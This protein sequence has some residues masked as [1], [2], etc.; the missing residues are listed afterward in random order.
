MFKFDKQQ[1]FCTSFFKTLILLALFVFQMDAMFADQKPKGDD[2]LVPKTAPQMGQFDKNSIPDEAEIRAKA[3]SVFKF[4]DQVKI[5]EI[6]REKDDLG[7]THIR[8]YFY[9]NGSRIDGGMMVAHILNGKIESI[10]GDFFPVSVSS[11]PSIDENT[12]LKDAMQKINATTYRWQSKSEEARLKQ[13]KKDINATW[14]PKAELVYCPNNGD[15]TKMTLAYK[16]DIFANEPLVGESIYVDAVSGKVIYERSLIR[17]ADSRGSAKTK[18][19]GTQV[20]TA[21]SIS[22]T[23][24]DLEESGR[25]GGIYTFNMKTGTSYGSAVDFTD[26]DNYWNNANAAQDEVAG[27]AHWGAEMTYDFYF[28]NFGRN[29]FDNAG[30]IIYSYVHYDSKY[31][32]AFWDGTE[33]NYGD[34]DGTNFT[35][36]TALDVCGHEISHGFTQHASNLAYQ[37]ESGAMDEGISDIFGTCIEFYAKDTLADWI[38]GKD[39]TVN[40][41]GIRDMSAPKN[42]SQPNTYNGTYYVSTSGTPTATNDWNGVHTNS[43]VLNYWFYLIAHGGSGTND[44]S[45]SYS[46][47]GLGIV[48]AQ[49]IMFRTAFYY[50]TTSSTFS[51]ARNYSI[52]AAIDL[53]GGCSNEVKQVTNAWYAV[54]IGAAYSNTTLSGT[55]TIGGTSPDFTTFTK[56]VA[57]INSRGICGPVTFNVRNGSYKE[58]IRIGSIIGTSAVNTVTFQSQNLDSTKVILTYASSSSSANDYTLELDSSNYI[59]FR[60][61]TIQRT[62]TNTYCNVVYLMDNASYN[63]ISNNVLRGQY[64][65]STSLTVSNAVVNCDGSATSNN[66]IYNNGI[67]GGL[68]GLYFYGVTYYGSD[69]EIYN[70]SVD[71]FGLSGI[72]LGYELNPIIYANTVKSSSFSSTTYGCYG[73]RLE[74]CDKGMTVTKNMVYLSAKATYCRGAALYNCA[75]TSG[76]SDFMWNNFVRISSGLTTSTGIHL[77]GCAYMLTL[78]N[79]VLNNYSSSSSIAI[80]VDNSSLTTSTDYIYNNNIVNKGG[81][82]AFYI[83]GGSV[84]SANY[85]N[86]YTSGT[87]IGYYSGGYTSLSNWK[88]GTGYDANSKNV[89]PGYTSANDLH[90]S[91][92]GIN[93]AAVPIT[94][95]NDDIDGNFRD[96]ITPDIGA[97]EFGTLSCM[98]DTFTIGGTSPDYATFKAAVSD[99][100]KKGVCGNVVF[101]VRNGTYTEQ[102]RIGSIPGSS[103]SSTITFQSQLGDS[104]KVILQYASSSSSTNN[105]TLMLD[106]ASYVTFRQ[107]TIQRTGSSTYG[108]TIDLED[109][110]SNNFFSNDRLLS[111]KGGTSGV[112]Q[113]VIYSAGSVDN[114]NV[115]YNNIIRHGCY[116][117]AYG[118]TASAYGSNTWIFFNTIDSFYTEGVYLIYTSTPLVESNHITALPGGSSTSYGI[119]I[120]YTT[121]AG[122]VADNVIYLK[123]GGYGLSYTN[124]T[125]SFATPALI[126]NNFITVASANYSVGFYLYSTGYLD[127]VYN[128]VNNTSTKSNASAAYIYA[129]G[130]Y[131]NLLNNNFVNKGGGYAYY[132]L[133][134]VSNINSDYNNLY[135]SGTNLCYWNSSNYTSLGS[136]QK[137]TLIDI[138]D[139]NVDPGY[140]NTTTDLHISNRTLEYAGTPYSGVTE[141]IDMQTRNTTTPTIGADEIFPLSCLNGTYT[142]GGTSPDFASFSAAIS[143]MRVSGICGPVVFNV[144]DGSYLEKISIGKISGSSSINT[145]TFQSQSLDSSKVILSYPSNSTFND[146]VLTIDTAS[147]VTFNE[148]TI[149]RSGSSTYGSCVE[150]NYSN[151]NISITNCRLIAINNSANSYGIFSNTGVDSNLTFNN[152]LVRHGYYGI[153]LQGKSSTVYDYNTTITNNTL[154]SFTFYGIYPS[155]SNLVTVTGNTVT[156][157]NSLSYYGIYLYGCNATTVASNKIYLPSGGYG[158]TV[159]N[160]GGTS[161][162]PIMVYNNFV[163]VAGSNAS[164]GI[165]I[166]QQN[167][168]VDLYYN[169]VNMTNSN[170]GSYTVYYNAKLCTV[171]SYDN[172]FVNSGGGY[173]LLM[174]NYVSNVTSNYNDYYYAGT[175]GFHYNST[176]YS[177]FSSYKTAS[178]KDANSKNVN[179]GFTS[180]TDL[181]ISSSLLKAGTPVSGITDDIDGQTRSTSTPTIGADEI[182]LSFSNDAGISLI[183]TPDSNVCKGTSG[184]VVTLENYGSNSLSSATI[185][186]SMNDTVQTAYS[187]SGTLSSG[188]TT[189]VT[190][191]NYNFSGSKVKIKVWTSSPNAAV[192]SNTT[193]DTANTSTTV[194]PLPSATVGSATSICSGSSTTIGGSS[195]SGHTYSWTSN[196]SGFTSTSNNPSVSPTVSTTYRLIET[197]SY[198]CIK[199]DS[200]KISVN[201]LPSV[202]VG[203]AKSICKGS[204]TGI[205]GSSTTGYTYS[206]TSNPSGFTSTSSNPSVSPTVTTVYKLTTKITATGCTKSDSVKI[207][208]N[209]QPTP[210]LVGATSVCANATMKDSTKNNSGDTYAW[211]ISGGS[212]SSGSSTNSVV[213]KWGSSGSGSLKVVE[214]NGSGCKD[215]SSVSVTIN[216]KPTPSVSG[217]S[218]V[219]ASSSSS[220]ST[221]KNSGNTYSWTI[222]GGTVSSGAGT[223]AIGAKWGTSGSGSVQVVETNSSGCKDS[224]SMSITINSTPSATVG[225]ATSICNGDSITLGGSSVSGNTYSWTST[226]SGF[227]SSSAS[228]KVAPSSTITYNLTETTTA[229]GC[230]KNNSAKITVNARPSAKVA[231]DTSVCGNTVLSLGASTVVGD[232]YKWTS[233]PSGYSDTTSNPKITTRTSSTT[234]YLTETIASSGCSKTDSV[235]VTVKPSPKAF[236]GTSQG[237]CNGSS[238]ILGASSVLGNTYSWTS[239]PSGFTSTTANPNVSPTVNTTYYLTEKVTSSGCSKSDSVKI[240]VNPLPSATVASASTICSGKSTSIGAATVK[241]SKYSWTSNPSGFT[242]TTSNPSV[243][244]TVTTTYYLTETI[245][246]TGCQKSDSVIVTVKTTPAV[247]TASNNGPLCP[248]STLD[249]KASSLAGAT[250]SWT[251]PNTFSSSSQNPSVTNVTKA[252]SGLYSVTVTSGGCTSN[253]GTTNVVIYAAPKASIS[254]NGSICAFSTQSYSAGTTTNKYS[255]TVSGGTISSGSGTN[256]IGITWGSSGKTW[257]KL[258][259]TNSNSCSDSITD[260]ITVNALPAASTGSAGS[261]C[262]GSSTSIGNTSVAGNTYSWTSKPGGFTSTSSNPSVSPYTSTTYYLTETVTATGCSKSDSVK[263]TVNPLPTPFLGKL[264]TPLCGGTSVVYGTKGN[265]GSSYSWTIGN[266]TITSGAGTDSINVNWNNGPGF[267]PIKVVETNAAGCK[268]SAIDSIV[269]NM[270]P[271]AKYFVGKT[272]FG[273][274]TSFA[275]SSTYHNKQT[276]Y[277]GDGNTSTSKNPSHTYTST[278]KYTVSL[279]IKNAVGCYDSSGTI[280]NIAPVPNAHFTSKLTG[281]RI[282]D[283]RADDTT[284]SST[285]YL[286]DFGDSSSANGFNTVHAYSADSTYKIQLIINN[287]GCT[288]S[289]DSSMVIFTG[290]AETNQATDIFNLDIYPNPFNEITTLQYELGFS[291]KIKIAVYAMD[292]KLITTLAEQQQSAGIHQFILRPDNYNLNQG[293]YFL[294]ILVGDKVITKQLIRVK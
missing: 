197:S 248:A 78:Y 211:Y 207:T 230:S 167:G 95:I 101:M 64:A 240:T 212:I 88:T 119:N 30:G 188:S 165:Y 47:T 21:D 159:S 210:S 58:Q 184:V 51:D 118:G 28:K 274:A 65:Y 129:T 2:P 261:I 237:I 71:S 7:Y 72:H 282:Y 267:G 27:D 135:S 114:Y 32:N 220:Y 185:N 168:Y 288:S 173:S 48:E 223:N 4:N 3:A 60:K 193:N 277:F 225:S 109:G 142:I 266:G 176:A 290:I 138:H 251:G 111:I 259:E 56:A 25:G 31:N 234:Y 37:N 75:S 226:P 255:W 5:V 202:T 9:Y 189:N 196:P 252:D 81:G 96:P 20:I 247:P 137:V 275:D 41:K 170:T 24:Y 98:H 90:V 292:G 156:A 174:D 235:V 43:G 218:S 229:S 198:G 278:G 213:V 294:R 190:I 91:A 200:V 99:L 126:A 285:S 144:R 107:M 286:W 155:W 161:S 209:P 140:S 39:F 68:S 192:D 53:Y 182:S 18:Y 206:W 133:N 152:N 163:A 253:A 258:V 15:I 84:Y 158:I 293:V 55:Y 166:G 291:A 179:P 272:C 151:K 38:I 145:I 216:A 250:Y 124:G 63:T 52:R 139:V 115:F 154:D 222:S 6:T 92:S 262:N 214:T 270:K 254:G 215:S 100:T 249:L 33:M 123:S 280:I 66:I 69:N 238:V 125:A 263:I 169:N 116:G 10:N 26:A 11:T 108:T 201:P 284:Y 85:N 208:L 44:N 242:D 146:Y 120:S 86:L 45:N 162:S 148:L 246:A 243:S 59:N 121:G 19:S 276:W 122:I 221:T 171:T 82:Y 194:R 279:A 97:D 191:G 130:C 236:A 227:T 74:Y 178:S 87:Y 268:D 110:A 172:I 106:T 127:V 132:V 94:G 281:K 113:S 217:S 80:N 70:N 177:S 34:G 128:N 271:T 61:M 244:P 205:G 57:A 76:Y 241:G 289:F 131:L 150:I 12:A 147:Y 245:A 224:S 264:V 233:N 1:V 67:H 195:T 183:K 105:Y 23:S 17:D 77:A 35:P 256:K 36:L 83:A 273:S 175:Y 232:K 149:K 14:F 160:C 29:S 117:I 239:N 203:S 13:I 134:N 260:T 102:V 103:S 50:F 180:S 73:I 283:F 89:D 219:C 22:S 164:Q 141:D 181:H 8:Y 287:S 136:L 49:K 16:F 79:N 228:I 42:F 46:V 40:G 143:Y 199:T 187:Y 93:G 54:G 157:Y 257:L 186:W 231:N 112:S 269:I 153:V 204:S 62:G 104:S 265:T